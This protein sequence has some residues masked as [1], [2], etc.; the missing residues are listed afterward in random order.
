MTSVSLL[1]GAL[2]LVMQILIGQQTGVKEGLIQRPA[3]PDL[4]PGGE[5]MSLKVNCK[6]N[7]PQENMPFNNCGDKNGHL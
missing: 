3:H 6:A 7:S 5:I 1:D 4:C 2:R